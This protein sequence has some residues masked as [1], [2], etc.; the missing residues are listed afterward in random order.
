MNAL[1]YILFIIWIIELILLCTLWL[2]FRSRDNI[3]IEYA[4][5]NEIFQHKGTNSKKEIIIESAY[6]ADEEEILLQS[7]RI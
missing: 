6:L 4:H 5:M 2:E 3:F 7:R 1:M